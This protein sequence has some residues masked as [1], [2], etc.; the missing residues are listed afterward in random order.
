M[1]LWPRLRPF[2]RYRG[3]LDSVTHRSFIN[4]RECLRRLFKGLWGKSILTLRKSREALHNHGLASAA[5][6]PG[7][8][9]HWSDA[10]LGLG[11]RA[12]CSSQY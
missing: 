6:P 3:F 11:C 10:S 1:K 9:R 7:A 2:N 8:I 4:L 5:P 12:P